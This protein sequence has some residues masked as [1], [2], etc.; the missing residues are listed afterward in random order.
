M[1]MSR[2][3]KIRNHLIKALQAKGQSVDK[4]TDKALLKAITKRGDE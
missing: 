3:Q 4:L 1:T 2:H